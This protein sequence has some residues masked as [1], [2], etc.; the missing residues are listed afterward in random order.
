MENLK[1]NDDKKQK[2]LE[3]LKKIKENKARQ[4]PESPIEEEEI[5]EKEP[6]E[7]DSDSEWGG[8]EDVNIP[9]AKQQLGIFVIDGSGS[10]IENT[11]GGTTKAQAVNMAVKETLDKFKKSRK[12]NWFYFSVVAFG[13]T[14]KTILPIQPV[15]SIDTHANYDPLRHFGGQTF[16]GSGL[17]EA[18][19][20][21]NNFLNNKTNNVPHSVIIIVLSDGECLKSAATEEIGKK[22]KGNAQ[23]RTYS[24]LVETLGKQ[25]ANAISLLKKI[26]TSTDCFQTVY[27]KDTIRD[28]FVHSLS[29]KIAL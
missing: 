21:A 14:A 5:E 24:C 6:E 17:S 7:E 2:A 19:N 15:A 11:N 12:K 18:L 27:D 16:I 8:M 1:N 29:T 28:F 26:A 20:I 23:I 10:M 4:N 22:I 9:I 3:I 13:E 25:D